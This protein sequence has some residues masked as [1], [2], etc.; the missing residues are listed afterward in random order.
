LQYLAAKKQLVQKLSA[1]ET[2]K[3]NALLLA[4][5]CCQMA[6]AIWSENR[7][8]INQ[9]ELVELWVQHAELCVDLVNM[10]LV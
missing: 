10:Q 4:T 1:E 5:H 8:L 7:S 2:T 9:D 3:R 6:Q